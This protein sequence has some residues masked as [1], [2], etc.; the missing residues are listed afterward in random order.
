MCE[1]ASAGRVSGAGWPCLVADIIF[2][3]FEQQ[4]CV[5]SLMVSHVV[6]EM[7]CMRTDLSAQGIGSGIGA[8]VADRHCAL[9][10]Y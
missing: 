5:L 9:L 4:N 6:M 10:R 2:S 7:A 1:G 8:L 3:L